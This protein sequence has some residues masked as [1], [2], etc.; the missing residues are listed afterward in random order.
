ML[1]LITVICV[2]TEKN[3]QLNIASL[4]C[5]NFYH[6]WYF[7]WGGGGGRGA[8]PPLDTPMH[9]NQTCLQQ[10]YQSAY[11]E[12]VI[13]RYFCYTAS[14]ASNSG[15]FYLKKRKMYQKPY[16]CTDINVLLHFS[17]L[18]ALI[19]RYN[20]VRGPTFPEIQKHFKIREWCQS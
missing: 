7:N 19:L 14:R 12:L 8:G 15:R 10:T 11:S 17:D 9:R 18:R 3:L 5:H 6:W 4:L 16:T 20:N 13:G 2:I 1:L